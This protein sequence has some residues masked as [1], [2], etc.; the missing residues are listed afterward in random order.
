ML[1]GERRGEG[2]W[3]NGIFPRTRIITGDLKFDQLKLFLGVSYA[4]GWC[5]T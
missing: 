3:G 2:G 4:N 5:W 1:G